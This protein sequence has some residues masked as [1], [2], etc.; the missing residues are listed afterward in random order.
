MDKLESTIAE[1][2]KNW[3][4][5]KYAEVEKEV[6]DHLER[7]NQE[8][9]SMDSLLVNLEGLLSKNQLDRKVFEAFMEKYKSV[10]EKEKYRIFKEFVER[11]QQEILETKE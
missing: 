1:L 11:G 8:L 10:D 3:N 9:E 2:E 4:P 5:E 6:K 7:H